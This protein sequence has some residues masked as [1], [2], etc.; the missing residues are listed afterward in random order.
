MIG[1]YFLFWVARAIQ[2]RERHFHV[3]LRVQY[4]R[5][6]GIFILDCARNIITRDVFPFGL[7]TKYNHA[8]GI[9]ILVAREI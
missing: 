1:A 7:R 8:R 3:G 6:R 4:N 9:F 2:S 5:A